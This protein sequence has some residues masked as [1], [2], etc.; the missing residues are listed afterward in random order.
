MKVG[1]GISPKKCSFAC[2]CLNQLIFVSDLAFRTH[3]TPQQPR[4]Y[5]KMFICLFLF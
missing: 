5:P 3:V 1:T 2:F 4:I